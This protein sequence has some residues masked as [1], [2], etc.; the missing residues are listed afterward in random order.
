MTLVCIHGSNA[1]TATCNCF[2]S[3]EEPVPSL[4]ATFEEIISA[5][6]YE[7]DIERFP[8]DDVR[9]SW[10]GNYRDI[11]V[12]LAWNVVCDVV[13]SGNELVGY[14]LPDSLYPG[15]KDWVTGNYPARVAWLHSMYESRTAELDALLEHVYGTRERIAQLERELAAARSLHAKG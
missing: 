1:M 7:K 13:A 9:Y 3:G 14:P 2:S 8:N 15:S 12:Q 4:R 5:S 10:P 11:N 6:P